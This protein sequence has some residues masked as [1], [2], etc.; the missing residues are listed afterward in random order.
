MVRFSNSKLKQT[1]HI[2]NDIVPVQGSS[3]GII[4]VIPT[5]APRASVNVDASR[6]TRNKVGVGVSSN[7]YDIANYP[8][9]KVDLGVLYSNGF[10]YMYLDFLATT[11]ACSEEI[12]DTVVTVQEQ[13]DDGPIYTEQVISGYT[14]VTAYV[15]SPVVPPLPVEDVRSCIPRPPLKVQPQNTSC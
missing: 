6:I 4:P 11:P 13:T 7:V 8:D 9:T 3:I 2:I 15:G 14:L 5:S 10:R 1:Q 12:P